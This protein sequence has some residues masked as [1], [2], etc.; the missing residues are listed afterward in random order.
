LSLSEGGVSS[1]KDTRIA[2]PSSV[3]VRGC[4]K[5]GAFLAKNGSFWSFLLAVF[6]R[7]G[8]FCYAIFLHT[9]EAVTVRWLKLNRLTMTVQSYSFNS[10]VFYSGDATGRAVTGVGRSEAG[11]GAGTYPAGGKAR[12]ARG[13]PGNVSRR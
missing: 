13:I 5:V 12:A 3:R 6:G 9:C 11:V 10:P 8:A 2:A 4:L 1:F 7:F